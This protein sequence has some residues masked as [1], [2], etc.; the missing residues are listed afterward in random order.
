MPGPLDGYRII[1]VTAM[2]SGPLATM[3]LADQ[4]A[5]VIKIENPIHGDFTRAVP[6]RRQGLS[7]AFLQQQPEQALRCAQPQGRAGV[8]AF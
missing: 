2:V 7:A 8:S 4:G 3:L 5:D 6:N 1:D